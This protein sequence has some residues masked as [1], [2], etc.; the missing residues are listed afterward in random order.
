MV[1]PAQYTRLNTERM[2]AMYKAMQVGEVHLFVT[3]TVNAMPEVQNVAN[4]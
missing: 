4:A 1:K 2:Q 3:A